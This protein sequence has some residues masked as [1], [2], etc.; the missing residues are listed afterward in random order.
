MERLLRIEAPHFVAGAV[1]EKKG[2][3]WNCIHAA[4]ILSWMIGK[5]PESV[6]SYLKRKRYKYEWVSSPEATKNS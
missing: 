1:W 2:D 3:H 6:V 5:S 4:P